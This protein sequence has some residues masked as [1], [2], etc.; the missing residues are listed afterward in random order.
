[1]DLYAFCDY[2]WRAVSAKSIR[3]RIQ[4][5]NRPKVFECS[6]FY[7][8]AVSSTHV[9]HI[10]HSVPRSAS[11]GAS[12][13]YKS[14][15]LLCRFAVGIPLKVYLWLHW[16]A[17]SLHRQPPQL[18]QVFW[19]LI[20][21][22]TFLMDW[23]GTHVMNWNKWVHHRHPHPVTVLE[24]PC[25]CATGF[26]AGRNSRVNWWGLCDRFSQQQTL[27]HQVW[28][29]AVRERKDQINRAWD[30]TIVRKREFA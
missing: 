8:L 28:C 10:S 20:Y 3:G 29:P 4:V 17:F 24:I 21:I 7:R 12:P 30:W 15:I 16:S 2:V 25:T 26:H 11:D 1:M 18:I 23:W 22:L 14:N 19:T 13:S 5:A 27:Y 9:T 6:I